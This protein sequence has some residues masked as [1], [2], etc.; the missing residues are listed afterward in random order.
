MSTTPMI[1]TVIQ[2]LMRLPIS[3][4]Q[5]VSDFVDSLAET[6]AARPR[7]F[8][9]EGLWTQ[10]GTDISAEEIATLR[11]EMWGEYVHEEAT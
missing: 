6:N 2:K 5:A 9:P 7:L 10:S 11:R 4:Q 3:Q 1:E 8:N